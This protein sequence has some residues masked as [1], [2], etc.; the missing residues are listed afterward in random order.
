[1]MKK[2]LP[3]LLVMSIFLAMAIIAIPVSSIEAAEEVNITNS[4]APQSQ[5]GP[6]VSVDEDGNFHMIHYYDDG[7]DYEARYKK[8]APDGMIITNREGI[9][10]TITGDGRIQ[11]MEIAS[12]DNGD[13]HIIFSLRMTSNDFLDIYYTQISSTG[14]VLVQAKKLFSSQNHS[15]LCDIG[16][17]DAGNAYLVWHE[18]SGS[19]AIYWMKVSSSGA[20]SQEAQVVS[21]D[22][23]I[24][25][26]VNRPRIGVD[27]SSGTSYVIWEQ[28]ANALARWEVY[29]SSLS[30]T[31]IVLEN[32]KSSI[33]SSLYDITQIHTDLDSDENLHVTY[34]RN[35]NAVYSVLDTEGNASVDQQTVADSMIGDVLAPDVGVDAND[36]VY[37]AYM[38]RANPS[39]AWNIYVRKRGASDD[40]WSLDAQLDPGNVSSFYPRMGAGPKGVGVAYGRGDDVLWNLVTEGSGVTNNP[41]VAMLTADRHTAEVNETINFDGGSSY[42]NDE[43]DQVKEYKFDWGDGQDTGWVTTAAVPYTYGE[44]GNYTVQLWVKDNQSLQCEEPDTLQITIISDTANKPPQAVLVADKQDVSTGETVTF[45]G[46]ASTDPDGQVE[47]YNFN[48]GDGKTTGWGD[49]SIKTHKYT[50]KGEYHATLQVKDDQ[51]KVSDNTA[52]VVINVGIVNTPPM[53]IIESILPNPAKEGEDVSF[54]GYGLDDEGTIEGYEWTSNKDGKLSSQA[55]FTVD[56]L[57]PGT[58][59][60]IFKVKDNGGLWSD[61]NVHTLTVVP[62]ER[63]TIQDNTDL[64]VT[65]TES[66]VEF[67][68][69]YIDEENDKPTSAKLVYA[70]GEQ[71][72]EEFLDPEDLYD[73]DCSDGKDY[74]AYVTITEEGTYQY[75]FVFLNPKNGEVKS[76]EGDGEEKEI[77]R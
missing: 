1:M 64:A 15:S 23:G 38:Q 68:C 4:E 60:I 2:R 72:W 21:G 25:G 74:H 31:G 22:L 6:S 75:W 3:V 39:S 77:E 46:G 27:P 36:D 50:Q 49:G 20:V 24:N 69:T 26:D 30:P 47:M 14:N 44:P 53:A 32:P 5:W 18:I 43:G 48:F 58:H 73:N 8:L 17:D 62:N 12:D 10:P 70:L 57:S 41:P 7:E 76:Q 54:K 42:D 59:Q 61:E 51:G 40:G 19:P 33:S 63:P 45:D 66:E 11:W 65:D 13:A 35:D 29:Y 9:N 16:A 37:C 34:I 52:K 56:T 71:T 67:R 55:V 28:K